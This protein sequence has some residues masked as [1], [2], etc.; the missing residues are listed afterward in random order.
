MPDKQPPIVEG[1]LIEREDG[2]VVNIEGGHWTLAM[3]KNATVFPRKESAEAYRREFGLTR[4]RVIPWC[5]RR[6]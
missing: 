4:A 2:L 6:S 3:L 5:D 1:W